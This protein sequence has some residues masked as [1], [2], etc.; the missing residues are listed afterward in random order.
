[1]YQVDNTPLGLFIQNGKT[2]S[3]LN[4]RSGSGNFY[5]K[6]NGVFYITTDNNSVVLVEEYIPVTLQS[7]IS[8]KIELDP[9]NVDMYMM[10]LL[11][12]TTHLHQRGIVH[13]DLKPSNILYYK[14]QEMI[15]VAD[16]GSM[17]QLPPWPLGMAYS[18]EVTTHGFRPP[19]ILLGSGRYGMPIDVW[20]VGVIYMSMQLGYNPFMAPF[21]KD[22][23]VYAS[24]SSIRS[25]KLIF[26]FR[27]Y[28]DNVSWPG[29]DVI[30]GYGVNFKATKKSHVHWPDGLRN[31]EILDKM[32]QIDPSKRC[33]AQQALEMLLVSSTA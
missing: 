33:T 14:D 2:L 11:G 21:N 1:M 32:L 31:I 12:A 6:P 7:I 17:R 4:T 19:E 9:N 18:P 30:N 26:E 29:F 23:D 27:G 20:S 8:L 16:F 24:K 5:L 10:Q 28:P 13:R 25:I 3:P 15:K 22:D